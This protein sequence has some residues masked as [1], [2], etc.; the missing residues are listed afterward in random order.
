MFA[1]FSTLC[2]HQS[3]LVHYSCFPFFPCEH[4]K[5]RKPVVF[6]SVAS[7]LFLI[8]M[9]SSVNNDDND[10]DNNNNNS[11]SDCGDGS[12]CTM[13]ALL[14]FVPITK[15]WLLQRIADIK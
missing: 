9:Y 5:S 6:R 14:V 3:C 8:V 12:T 10:D 13:S 7:R 1:T 2:L 4:I 15:T 11:L